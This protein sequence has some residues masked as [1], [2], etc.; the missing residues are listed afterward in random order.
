[1]T[2]SLNRKIA[3]RYSK[4]VSNEN[5]RSDGTLLATATVYDSTADLP[6]SGIE[7]GAQ[8]YVSSNQR[9]YIRGTGGWYNIATINNTPTI[10]SVQTA[11]GDSSPFTLATD[12]STTT[13][14]TI[15]A[16][17]TEGF[18]ITFS[19]TTDVGFD[20]IATVSNDSSVFTITPLSEDSAGTATSGTLTF[21][22]SDG[23]N[24]ASEVATFTIVFKVDNSA[25]TVF[26]V[27][28]SGNNKT[29]DAAPTDA[30]S[31]TVTSSGTY[32][33]AKSPYSRRSV[34]FRNDA[35]GTNYIRADAALDSLTS[36]TPDCTFEGWYYINS[37]GNTTF[38]ALF[39]CNAANDGDN[40]LIAAYKS[41]KLEIIYNK[42]TTQVST[43]NIPVGEW[44][45]L[46]VT[47][48]SSDGLR[49]YINGQL[50][51]SD[52][53]ETLHA[54]LSACDFLIGAEF[55]SNESVGNYLNGYVSDFRIYLFL[56]QII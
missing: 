32:N 43:K 2:E 54:A 29:N 39:G 18:P 6:T 35:A 8:G 37:A 21:K 13:V 14:I 25:Y 1:M 19:A 51:I 31:N 10:N 41:N 40:I 53:V 15:T 55:D 30:K 27:K 50:Y 36:T 5:F 45:Y 3:R 16:T 42:Q 52:T 17:D 26:L 56:I 48:D 24:I 7:R 20:S 12:G 4:A 22:A 28:G 47:L 44:F 9:L 34:I 11:G 46:T 49:A 38:E 23:V 33:T